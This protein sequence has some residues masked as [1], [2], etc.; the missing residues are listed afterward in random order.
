[1]ITRRDF[2]SLASASLA[3]H[4]LTGT[5]AA[6]SKKSRILILGGTGFIGPYQIHY[7]LDQG[8]Q[9]SMFNRGRRREMFGDRVEVLVGNRDPKVDAGLNALKGKRKWD[10]V[11]DNSGYI[12]R[13][14]KASAELLKNRCRRYV[15][16]SSISVYDFARSTYFDE[17]SQLAKPV[18]TEKMTGE[19]YG[20]LKA[21]CDR[22]VRDILGKKATVVRPDYIVG[23]GDNTDR[24]TYWIDRVYRG[25]QVLAPGAP[26]QACSW[27]DVRDLSPWLIELGIRN[28]AGVFNASGPSSRI[29]R[30]GMLWGG[31][32]HDSRAGAV[33]LAQ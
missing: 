32:S 13:H 24:F 11:I 23:P 5:S 4:W 1:M 33:S 29:S 3:A 6:K 8:H 15:F 19:T 22:M 2:L 10:V 21:E 17:S 18:N 14:V 9:V 31:A 27:V 26:D 30:R 16:V 20:A 25:G 28:T 12:P 7:A